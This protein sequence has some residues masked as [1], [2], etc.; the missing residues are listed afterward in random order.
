MFSLF[1]AVLGLH[2]AQALL[3]VWL[4][5]AALGCRSRAPLTVE[6]GLQGVW[7]PLVALEHRLSSRA[8]GGLVILPG[9]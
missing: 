4:A 8:D 6:Q 9:T 7:V 1:L 5:A 3:W 2:A